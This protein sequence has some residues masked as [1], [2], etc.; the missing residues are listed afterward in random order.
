[1]QNENGQ[2]QRKCNADLYID[3]NHLN[4]ANIIKVGLLR[5][6]VHIIRMVNAFRDVVNRNGTVRCVSSCDQYSVL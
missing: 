4:T 6:A 5:R 3:F 2:Q 1:M